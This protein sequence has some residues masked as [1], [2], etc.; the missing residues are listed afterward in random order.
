MIVKG[1]TLALAAVAILLTIILACGGEASPTPEPVD[2]NEQIAMAVQKALEGLPAPGPSGPTTE[3]IATQIQAAVKA[4]MESTAGAAL[5]PEAVAAMVEQALSS[6]PGSDVSAEEI[7]RLVQMAVSDQMAAMPTPAATPAP[8]EIPAMMGPHGV[9]DV[10]VVDLGAN[11]NVLHNQPLSAFRFDNLVTHEH[12]FATTP[13]NRVENRLVE[14]WSS[15]ATGLVYTLNLK[16]GVPWHRDYGDFNAADFIFSIEDVVSAGSPHAAAGHMRRIWTCDGCEL[17]KID[18]NTVQLTR[19][20]PTFQ[21]TWHSRSPR[22][23][24]VMAMHSK[25]HYD[26]VGEDQADIESVGTGPW[27]ATQFRSGDRRVVEAVSDHWRKTPEFQQMVWHEIQ[28]SSTR[29]ANFLIGLLDTGQFTT[30]DIQTIKQEDLG[31]VRFMQV[32][33]GA[34]L[35]LNFL[36][37]QYQTDHPAHQPD[38][39]GNIRVPLGDNAYDC[40]VA[41]VSC[42]RDL[43][44][45]EWERARKVRL[46]MSLAIDRQK[47]LNNLAFGEGEPW[48]VQW[49]LGHDFRL[50]Q[51]GLD[52]LSWDYDPDQAKAIL[53]EVAPDGIEIDLAL[54]EGFFPGV[55]P[56]IEAVGTMWEGIGITTK[57]F[58]MPF[59]AY[60]PSLVNRTAKAIHP[61]GDNPGLSPL[62]AYDLFFDPGS[63]LNL[64]FEHPW[65]TQKLEEA[66]NTLDDDARWAIL[67]EMAEWMF[68][69]VMVMPLYRQATVAPVG[70]EINV[71][72]LQALGSNLLNNYEFVTHREQ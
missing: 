26:A 62:P 9:L 24:S 15:D 58:N 3:E 4:S 32:P 7:A 18:D 29:V 33:G 68:D 69:N 21:I 46:A 53:A 39:E 67:A 52:E 1:K 64:G 43:E 59:S 65:F 19:P 20:S 40:T 37:Q 10:G 63:G 12:M 45:E 6:L 16:Q 61:L 11:V 13:D 57:G 25:A 44:S 70:S 60:R 48:F 14:D 71:W 72:P 42:D 50:Q 51:F 28:E 35:Y 17:T 55:I 54:S 56:V 49:W 31:W 2:T 30:A 36:G 66:G 22:S 47:L 27:M 8:T 23:G 41:Y 34:T 5:S 38:A